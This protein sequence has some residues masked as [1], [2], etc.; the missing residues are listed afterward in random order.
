MLTVKG[1]KVVCIGDRHIDDEYK[2]QHKNYRENTYWCMDKTVEITDKEKPDFYCETG[3]FIG[4]RN[5]VATLKD[6]LML[7]KTINYLDSIHCEKVIN[8]GNHD[9]FELENVNTY[10]LLSMLGKFKTPREVA[11]AGS[12]IGIVRLVSPDYDDPDTGEKMEI[13]IHFVPYGK[14]HVQLQPVKG[15]TNVAITH[16]DFRVS[17]TMFTNNP[18]AIDLTT[19]EPFFGMDAI[20]NGHIHQPSNMTTFVTSAGTNCAFINLGCMARPKVSENYN[21][22]WYVDFGFRLDMTGKPEAYITPKPIELIPADEIFIS[23]VSDETKRTL[24]AEDEVQLQLS[25]MFDELKDFNWAG[26]SILDRINILSIEEPVKD[27][28]LEY[29]G[30]EK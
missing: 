10:T 18:E 19:H 12:D 7:Y 22:V 6:N 4:V 14:E 20:I 29:Y 28:I 27:I 5:N 23:R 11:N 1:N 21:M 17:S 15:A 16:N 13:Y 3:D 24:L 30:L 8:F 26:V 25:G 2:G 9:M